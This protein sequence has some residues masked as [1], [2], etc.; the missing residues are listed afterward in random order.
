MKT[1]NTPVIETPLYDL[2]GL[3]QQHAASVILQAGKNNTEDI[4]FGTRGE[5]DHFL[6]AS[7]SAIYPAHDLK[8]FLVKAEGVG[9]TLI[10]TIE[11][12]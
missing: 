5:V 3:S 12:L 7:D 9:Q 8:H 2:F 6:E 11:A 1:T 4:L 10:V